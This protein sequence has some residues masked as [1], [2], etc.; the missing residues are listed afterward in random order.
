MLLLP[1]VVL[2]G[3][4]LL[5]FFPVFKGKGKNLVQLKVW[6]LCSHEFE[7][8]KSH[9]CGMPPAERGLRSWM[10]ASRR[11]FWQEEA[12]TFSRITE[13]QWNVVQEYPELNTRLTLSLRREK[14][15][16]KLVLYQVR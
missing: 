8:K 9:A 3:I 2:P 16:N 5:F 1:L 7:S 13:Q 4:L 11:G 15:F 6:F 10:C 14:D 12:G